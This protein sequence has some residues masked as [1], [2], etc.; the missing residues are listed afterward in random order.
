MRSALTSTM[1]TWMW[2]HLLAIIEHAVAKRGGAKVSSLNFR[3]RFHCPFLSPSLEALPFHLSSTLLPF[4]HVDCPLRNWIPLFRTFPSD[5]PTCSSFSTHVPN[6]EYSTARVSFAFPPL[7]RSRTFERSEFNARVP[8]NYPLVF[9]PYSSPSR[10]VVVKSDL[11]GPPTYPAPIQAIFF[12]FC[13]K[14]WRKVG[15]N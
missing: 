12:T 13:F 14:K 1:V 8:R 3:K 4:Q 7:Y 15:F 6:I 11:L 10:A 9:P 5:F 2:G